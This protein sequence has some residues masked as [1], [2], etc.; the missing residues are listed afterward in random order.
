MG[1]VDPDSK[2]LTVSLHDLDGKRLWGVDLQPK[3]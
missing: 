1:R 3:A 2:A